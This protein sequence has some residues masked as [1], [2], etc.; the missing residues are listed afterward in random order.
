MN[1]LPHLPLDALHAVL[2]IPAMG[3]ALLALLP[4]Y[5]LAARLN[6]LIA[7]ATLIAALSL[8]LDRPLPGGYLFVDDLN[9]VFVVLSTFVGFTTA[10][11][12]ATYIGHELAIGRLTPRNLR[13]YHA[14]YRC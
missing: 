12:S 14:M 1:A 10:V 2:M 6:F 11:F 3:A 7:L 13:F 4:G 8:L 9:V 5:W